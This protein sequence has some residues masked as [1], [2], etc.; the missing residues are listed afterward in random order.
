MRD[1][2]LPALHLGRGCVS[3][4]GAPPRTRPE[5]RDCLQRF[6]GLTS[7][8]PLGEFTRCS[9]LSPFQPLLGA[10]WSGKFRGSQH[11]RF[12]TLW[13]RCVQSQTVRPTFGLLTCTS[14]HLLPA[15]PSISVGLNALVPARDSLPASR[16]SWQVQPVASA[17]NESRTS[18]KPVPELD[19]EGR[20]GRDSM[21]VA[22]LPISIEI[23]VS[24]IFYR[25]WTAPLFCCSLKLPRCSLPQEIFERERG[26]GTRPVR[27]AL[28][29]LRRAPPLPRRSARLPPPSLG[30]WCG[31]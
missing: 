23:P 22:P 20:R 14:L 11:H 21:R 4:K 2:G 30:R 24:E 16:D 17:D 8:A 9:H 15:C 29:W 26:G 28:E 19:F 10:N 6:N 18:T 27:G 7:S 3:K 5:R 1:S 12:R 25:V 31:P 13:N